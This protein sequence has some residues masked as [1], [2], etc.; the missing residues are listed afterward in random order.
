[1]WPLLQK[2]VAPII[3]RFTPDPLEVGLTA[4][5]GALTLYYDA[6]DIG[7]VDNGTLEGAFKQWKAGFKILAEKIPEFQAMLPKLENVKSYKTFFENFITESSTKAEETLITVEGLSK[8]KGPLIKL[9]NIAVRLVDAHGSITDREFQALI[10]SINTAPAS[11][12]HS[13]RDFLGNSTEQKSR[14]LLPEGFKPV[15]RNDSDISYIPTGAARSS[16][17]NLTQPLKPAPTTPIKVETQPNA[18]STLTIVTTKAPTSPSIETG[19]TTA[20]GELASP[21]SPPPVATSTPLVESTAPIDS[22]LTIPQPPPETSPFSI[23]LKNRAE[24]EL[25]PLNREN[26]TL[27]ETKPTAPPPVPIIETPPPANL[28]KL[29]PPPSSLELSRVDHTPKPFTTPAVAASEEGLVAR[30]IESFQEAGGLSVVARTAKG[31]STLTGVGLMG[32]GIEEILTAH[33]DVDPKTG[34]TTQ[35]AS[36]QRKI[37]FA[38]TAAGLSVS[39]LGLFFGYNATKTLGGTGLSR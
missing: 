26:P 17:A 9:N 37:G 15:E 12:N 1:M 5:R 30:V 10:E 21:P 29:E 28:A 19:G 14:K 2:L 36:N 39:L 34:K 11:T 22:A 20:T 7:I 35:S 31:V 18:P 38:L 4:L 27:V 8:Q 6:K 24:G 13:I 16:S 33:N 32:A 3:Q 25:P 23:P